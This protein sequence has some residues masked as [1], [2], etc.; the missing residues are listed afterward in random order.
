M[1]Y[2]VDSKVDPKVIV[3]MGG[4]MEIAAASL[5]ANRREVHCVKFDWLW[6]TW[7]L[8]AF[9]VPVDTLL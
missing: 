2:M 7:V 1:I 9:C 8:L 6:Q 5:R 3:S 4:G